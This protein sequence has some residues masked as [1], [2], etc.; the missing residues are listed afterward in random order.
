[1][2]YFMPWDSISSIIIGLHRIVGGDYCFMLQTTHQAKHE[3]K[4]VRE[5]KNRTSNSIAAMKSHC[6]DH[7]LQSDGTIKKYD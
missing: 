2:Q 5:K 7:R 1:M 4:N 3:R 6:V